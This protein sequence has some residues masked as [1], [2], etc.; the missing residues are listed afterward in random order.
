MENKQVQN[1]TTVNNKTAATEPKREYMFER[2]NTGKPQCPEFGGILCI[3]DLEITREAYKTRNNDKEFFQYS[4]CG[5]LMGKYV[6]V[7]LTAGSASSGQKRFSDAG[8]YDLLDF[9]YT[10]F[11]DVRF[12]VKVE[13]TA[14]R[15][16]VSFY[17]VGIAPNGVVHPVDVVI[18]RPSSRAKLA[19][20]LNN[21]S[22]E[23]DDMVLPDIL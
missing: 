13:S 6:K 7:D 15:R 2:D 11:D 5:K 17:V 21:I 4:V 22:Y 23:H 8:I 10:T 19:M 20:L 14:E 16:R 1:E 12:G 18:S 9:V 3:P